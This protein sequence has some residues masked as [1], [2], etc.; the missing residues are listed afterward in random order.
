MGC[1]AQV[2]TAP[3]EVPVCSAGCCCEDIITPVDPIYIY[4]KEI[5][6]TILRGTVL[7]GSDPN[8]DGSHYSV[9]GVVVIATAP[10]GKNYV[11]ITNDEGTYSICVS[12]PEQGAP[13]PLI[14]SI[15]AYCCGCCSGCCVPAPCECNC[16][17]NDCCTPPPCDC[18]CNGD[19]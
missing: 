4:M 12:A 17:D 18:N 2:P 6:A 15:E 13:C 7:C 5:N 14:Y 10:D 3:V 8:P 11:G 1:I 9:A 16:C 19:E